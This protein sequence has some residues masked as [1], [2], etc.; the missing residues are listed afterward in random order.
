[1]PL[2]A[3]K[4]LDE[5][6]GAAARAGDKAAFGKLAARW[7]SKLMAHAYRLL[8]DIESARDVVQDGWSDIVKNL[9][10]LDDTAAFPAW[11]YRIISRRAADN[12][13]KK[14]RTRKINQAYAAEPRE[15]NSAEY[16]IDI[17][18]DSSPLRRAIAGLPSKQRAAIALFYLEEFSVAETAVAL[19][20]PAGTVK[21][22]LMKARQSL[23]AILEGENP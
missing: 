6:L 5:Y 17:D 20:V 13:R 9:K 15:S 8:G 18:A 19:S 21:T 12:I 16:P 14:Q 1:M 7:Q 2:Q 22:R 11:A 23:R 10:R 4:I 3:A